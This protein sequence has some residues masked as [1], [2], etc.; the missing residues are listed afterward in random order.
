M[1]TQALPEFGFRENNINVHVH[2]RL[3]CKL[4]FP[5]TNRKFSMLTST[6]SCDNALT[7]VLHNEHIFGFISVVA[8]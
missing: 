6:S 5:H 7:I 8:F 1:Q 2:L 3:E 4:L